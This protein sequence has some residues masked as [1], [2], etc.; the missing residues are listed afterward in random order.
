MGKQTWILLILMGLFVLVSGIGAADRVTHFLEAGPVVAGMIAIFLTAKRFPLT[1]I[2]A[3]LIVVHS[4]I[5]CLGAHYTYAHVP[6]GFWAKEAFD[7]SRNH[8]DRLGHVAQGFIPAI[9]AREILI[10]RRIVNGRVWTFVIATCICLAFSAFYE[11][12]EW[13]VALFTGD[14]STEFL[15]TQGDV[16]DTQWDMFFALLGAIA[17]QL[18]L[19]KWHDRQIAEVEGRTI[20]GHEIGA[21]R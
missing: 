16:W 21:V 10:R 6:L 20:E 9:L 5:L 3:F 4:A 15:G 19:G 1:P 12:I 18:M 11:L 13:W 7:F 17:S 8:Y 14:A 2:L